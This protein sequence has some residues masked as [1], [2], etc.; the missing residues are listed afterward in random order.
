MRKNQAEGLRCLR[1]LPKAH[2]HLHLTGSIRSTTFHDLR[3]KYGFPP[4]AMCDTSFDNF[5]SFDQIYRQHRECIKE[6]ED[7]K[8]I[9]EE[10][11]E[12]AAS[13]GVWW[14]EISAMMRG[15]SE[16]IGLP[17]HDAWNLA[18][19]ASNGAAEKFG[20]G[21]S[22]IMTA[23][24]HRSS[25]EAGQIG[26]D[27]ILFFNQ[28]KPV[29]GFGCVGKEQENFDDFATIFQFIRAAGLPVIAPHAGEQQGPETVKQAVEKLRATRL[30]HGV[31]AIEDE[32]VME[33][34]VDKNICLD[35]CPSSN[36]GLRI[37]PSFKDYPLEE[38]IK[39]KIPCSINADDP[40]LFDTDIVREYEICRYHM[41]L[42]D[43]QLA[44]CA[45]NSFRFS[46]AP[47]ETI[48]QA[49]SAIDRWI[50]N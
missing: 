14:V 23:V 44:E 40:T 46:G 36:I 47:K 1:A 21:A 32:N 50:Q 28:G 43:E 33:L 31:R 2:L 20:I 8:R 10:L 41:G 7:L 42:S 27:A 9:V 35:L 39:R 12:D 25:K 17:L 22:W 19:E 11:V 26:A 34:L 5:F 6:P 45:R 49:L 16:E 30:G 29:I 24:R 18:F 13:Q 4:K 38:F 3:R 15:M 37:F 48:D